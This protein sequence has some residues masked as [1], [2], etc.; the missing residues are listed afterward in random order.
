MSEGLLANKVVSFLTVG[1]VRDNILRA[2]TDFECL[3]WLWSAQL[4]WCDH[5]RLHS[6]L[7]VIKRLLDAE[8]DYYTSLVAWCIAYV[9]GWDN[10]RYAYGDRLANFVD[11]G[12]D[13]RPKERV[14]AATIKADVLTILERPSGNGLLRDMA[15]ETAAV[16]KKLKLLFAECERAQV[17]EKALV[18]SKIMVVCAGYPALLFQNKKLERTVKRKL[19]EFLT[20]RK[21]TTVAREVLG[22]LSD[23]VMPTLFEEPLDAWVATM[24]DHAKKKEG[25]P[26]GFDPSTL[27][28]EE[29]RST[30]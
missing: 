18:A 19:W 3:W 11:A 7:D 26:E 23:W 2:E 13:L 30:N 10:T 9:F 28:S 5:A 21:V 4:A 1:R 12:T 20:D 17:A 8:P 14:A 6:V 24:I 16:S 25:P 15:F 22:I 27:P 29:A